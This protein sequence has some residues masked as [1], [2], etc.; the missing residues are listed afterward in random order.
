MKIVTAHEMR[1]IDE[2]AQT[3][4]ALDGFD[5][6]QHAARAIFDHAEATY[7]P[8]RVC[9][10]CGKGNNAGDGL[11][12]AREFYTLGRTVTL[13]CVEGTDGFSGAA[14]SAWQAVHNLR[15]AVRPPEE[16]AAVLPQCDLVIDALLGT[17]IDGA[18]REH[19]A[20]AIELVNASGKP[21]VAADVPSGLRR[22]P[23]GERPSDIIKAALTVTIGLPKDIMLGW[24][25]RPWVGRLEVAPINFPPELL[26]DDRWQLN[27]TPAGAVGEWLPRRAPDSHKGTWGHVG[28]VG[29]CV[30]F[31]GASVLAAR[32]ALRAGCGLATIY[33]PEATAPVYQAAL[34]EAI[35]RRLASQDD[36]ALDE[37]SA[38]AFAA[39]GARHSIMVVGP[40][41]GTSGASRGF[42]E[43]FL[44]DWTGPLLLDADALN[45]LAAHGILERIEGRVDCLLTPHPA[46]M[47]RLAGCTVDVV[48]ADRLTTARTAAQRHR[49]H[50][51]LK[52]ADT[53]VAC[54]SGQV[55]LVP[56][57][58]PALAKGGSGDVLSGVIASLYAQGM[59]LAQA[60]VAGVTLQLCAADHASRVHGSR[61]VLARDVAD[62]I[63]LAAD[64]V[65]LLAKP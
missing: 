65:A 59:G 11:L 27:W 18:P 51:L 34:P 41:M 45:L 46:E 36:A 2:L 35:T 54:P 52:G 61:G 8:D 37:S 60:A 22:V 15:I 64:R 57:G 43:R 58:Q 9:V 28:I 56:G 16:L 49:V 12:V 21:V 31:A 6:M 20:R 7:R 5:L 38:E 32:A 25:A 23:P 50:V 10:L 29:A 42:L 44:Q 4:Y 3:Q 24:Q 30:D 40:G 47:A 19:Y 17:G 62:A 39:L 14:A 13:V 26:T 48:Q 33:A 63:P 1:R 53:L 55:W